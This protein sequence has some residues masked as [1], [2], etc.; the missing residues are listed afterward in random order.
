MTTRVEDAIALRD[1]VV[2]LARSDG[3]WELEAGLPELVWRRSKWT[4][5]FSSPAELAGSG[6]TSTSAPNRLII[7]E[8]DKALFR[9]EWSEGG[10][11]RVMVFQRG[12]W[13]SKLLS[14]PREV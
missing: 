12:A 7:L 3:N 13:E 8:G 1:H 11:I 14:L 6:K 2:A 4:A 5:R 10:P 9:A